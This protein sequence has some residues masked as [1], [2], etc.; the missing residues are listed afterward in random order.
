MINED[1]PISMLQRQLNEIFSSLDTQ[2]EEEP[3]SIFKWVEIPPQIQENFQIG[4]NR[5][6]RSNLIVEDTILKCG[7]ISEPELR[8]LFEAF[9]NASSKLPQG[10]NLPGEY[11][12]KHFALSLRMRSDEQSDTYPA[13]TPVRDVRL[14]K[15]IFRTGLTMLIDIVN[16]NL[17]SL[18]FLTSPIPPYST[19][20]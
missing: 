3:S 4:L 13:I 5:I 10:F 7:N 2:N 14:D 11:F 19:S 17:G 1:Q 8:S 6:G 18:E 16:D 15:L 12:S 20:T 9:R